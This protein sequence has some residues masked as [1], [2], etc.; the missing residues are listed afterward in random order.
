M[1]ELLK[2]LIVKQESAWRQ[3]WEK[4]L[5]GAPAGASVGASVSALIGVA[6]G[7][8][9]MYLFDPNRG[10][11]RRAWSREKIRSM[12]L[13]SG[14][15]ADV[16]VRDAGNRL[17]GA[18]AKISRLLSRS[19]KVPDDQ[20]VVARVRAR[21]GRIIANPHAIS[22]AV[23]Q[24][25]LVLSGP[26][27]SH[28]KRPLLECV[29]SVSGVLDVDDRLDA[30]DYPD[31]VPGLQ[32]DRAAAHKH[33]DWAPAQRGLAIVGGSALG[34]YGMTRRTPASIF[35]AVVGLALLARGVRS[36]SVARPLKQLAGID[37]DASMIDL[38][39]SID[40]H[41]APET[42]FDLCS[43]YA[44]FPRF[45]PHIQE[46]RD[47]GLQRSHWIAKDTAGTKFEWDAT[48]TE[49]ARPHLLAWKSEPGAAVIYAAAMHFESTASGTHVSVRLLCNAA[50]MLGHDP[51]QTLGEDL[52]RMKK[53]IEGDIPIKDV[54]KQA[55]T[56]SQM[57]H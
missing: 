21:I 8:A 42:V 1:E 34:I 32:G 2:E 37:T 22:V 33:G 17:A 29:Q 47:L 14:A 54:A 38:Q 55:D 51:Q 57:L 35:L 25:H 15:A 19:E 50:T 40:I 36:P 31:G 52:L 45:M 18:Q 27:L 7:A 53:F 6:L 44:S 49:S 5:R 39:Q 48:Q 28:E 4:W 3:G 24:G 30:H 46:V 43:N 13:K 56:A 23:Q 41:A 20:V 12:A 26:I 11:Q 16:V 9:A 10:R